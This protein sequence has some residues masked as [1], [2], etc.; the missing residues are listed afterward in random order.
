MDT[1]VVHALLALRA[2]R[3]LDVLGR[4]DADM[5]TLHDH[6]AGRDTDG[7]RVD[8][9][10]GQF[11]ARLQHIAASADFARNA[12]P[13]VGRADVWHARFTGHYLH[14]SRPFPYKAVLA[15]PHDPRSPIG[16]TWVFALAF[17]IEGAHRVCS[18]ERLGGR[19]C[20]TL[21]PRLPGRPLYVAQLDPGHFAVTR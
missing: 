1:N 19:G 6:V 3:H 10:W 8:E 4:G 20:R 12:A 2:A 5:A 7:V 11:A 15:V 18:E 17:H 9:R 14:L 13:V 21:W 16:G